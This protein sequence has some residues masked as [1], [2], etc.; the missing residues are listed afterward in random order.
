MCVPAYRSPGLCPTIEPDATYVACCGSSHT[1]F[2]DREISGVM[3]TVKFNVC[4]GSLAAV[5]LD[6]PPNKSR[7]R[8]EAYRCITVLHGIRFDTCFSTST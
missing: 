8:W 6:F 2:T 3:L 7:Q 4:C 5:L 1:T